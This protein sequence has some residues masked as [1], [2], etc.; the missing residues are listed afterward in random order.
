MKKIIAIFIITPIIIAVVLS[1]GCGRDRKPDFSDL[2]NRLET[3]KKRN[4][5][6]NIETLKNTVAEYEELLN[7]CLTAFENQYSAL[8]Y[9]GVQCLQREMYDLAIQYLSKS[10]TI[11][12]EDP[13]L[14]Y[15]LGIAYA[16]KGKRDHS[17]N[18]KAESNYK[19]ALE[20]QPNNSLILYSLA[21]LYYYNQNLK[22]EAIDI[23]LKSYEFSGKFDYKPAA[24][25][26]RFYLDAGDNA[27]ALKY[28]RHASERASQPNIKAKFLLNMGLVYQKM[29]D[30][31]NAAQFFQQALKT[32]K[33]L[34]EA[35]NLLAG[36][37]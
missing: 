3:L 2:R 10:L 27:E 25:L 31:A 5:S 18:D 21:M 6:G 4:P 26:A 19:L 20:L 16:Y 17:F 36:V 7:I 1:A 37:K 8:R 14:Y 13:D 15:Y 35:R 23:M 11:K 32:D 34:T 30:K 22:K 24:M 12:S 9:L 29:N 33:H 28:Y